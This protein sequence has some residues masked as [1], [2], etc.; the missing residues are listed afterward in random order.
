MPGEIPPVGAEA[1]V[2]HAFTITDT[3]RFAE[4]NGDS[5][6]IH[7]DTVIAQREYGVSAPIVQGMLSASLFATIFGRTVPGCVYI[8]QE[9]RFRTPLLVDETVRARIKVVKLQKRFVHCETI[10]EKTS[11]QSVV[12]EGKAIVLLPRNNESHTP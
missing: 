9:L 12:V 3:K 4:I 1:S 6:P 8:S 10:C 7:T 5:N 2:T 11:D